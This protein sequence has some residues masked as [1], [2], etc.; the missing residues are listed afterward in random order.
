MVGELKIKAN[1]LMPVIFGS[2]GSGSVAGVVMYDEGFVL[3]TGSWTLGDGAPSIPIKSDASSDRPR[4]IYFGAGALDGVNQST[5]GAEFVS[6]S[7]NMS[8][9]GQTDTQVVTM[10][11]HAKRG[12]VNYSN[13]PTFIKHGQRKMDISSSNIFQE[14]SNKLLINKFHLVILIT[15]LILKDKFT[16]QE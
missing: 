3:L 14:N 11:A 8:F 15:T 5:A 13:N 2:V 1:E 10:F 9:R 16:Y 7:F 12:E 6:A 4:W